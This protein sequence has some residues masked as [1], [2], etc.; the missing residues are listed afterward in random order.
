MKISISCDPVFLETLKMPCLYFRYF[1]WRGAPL[2]RSTKTC[3]KQVDDASP[4]KLHKHLGSVVVAHVLPEDVQ[5]VIDHVHHAV[6]AVGWNTIE[7]Q[8]DCPGV[9]H[10]QAHEALR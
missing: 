2:N 1:S 10:G 8:G 6:E 4:P 3:T 5:D 7:V 9:Q